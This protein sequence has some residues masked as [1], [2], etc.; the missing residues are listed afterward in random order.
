MYI[1]FLCFMR[2]WN[3]DPVFLI[4]RPAFP[5]FV[6]LRL[7]FFS[8]LSDEKFIR[9]FFKKKLGQLRVEKEINNNIR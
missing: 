9:S 2:V 3:R 1:T 5:L 7:H 4:L 8:R 6:N